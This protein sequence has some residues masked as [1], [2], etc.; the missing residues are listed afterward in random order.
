MK[1]LLFVL[2]FI[3]NICL[4]Q[5]CGGPFSKGCGGGVSTITVTSSGTNIA[6]NVGIGSSNPIA[7]LDVQGSLNL[8]GYIST[9][10]WV[11]CRVTPGSNGSICAGTNTLSSGSVIADT[12]GSINTASNSLVVA[13]ASGWSVGMGISVAQ[14]G[15]SGGTIELIT[16]IT[17]I[18]GTTFTLNNVSARSVNLSGVNVFHDDT[19]ALIA[20]VNGTKNV[21]VSLGNYNVTSEV[22]QVTTSNGLMIWGDGSVN[23]QT[24]SNPL[25]TVVGGTV[26]WN[27]GSTNN[28]INLTVSYDDVAYF[29]V[30][31]DASVTPSA[32]YAFKISDDSSG[33]HLRKPTI[34]DVSFFGVYN[35]ISLSGT[36][37]QPW[38]YNVFGNTINIA[39][40]INM[41]N[42]YG[43]NITNVN[44][45]PT[46][47]GN[48]IGLDIVSADESEYNNITY[49]G[50]DNDVLINDTG[51]AGGSI[52]SQRFLGGS[53]ENGNGVDP[54]VSISPSSTTTVS[55]IKFVGVEF[56][57]N[58]GAAGLL[59][60]T[61]STL[62]SILGCH[63][64]TM[65]TGIDDKSTIGFNTIND[66]TFKS[67]T[68]AVSFGTGTPSRVPG[69]QMTGNIG[70]SSVQFSNQLNLLSYSGNPNIFRV[71]TNTTDS[72]T[73]GSFIII[74]QDGNTIT[75]IGTRLGGI[76]W[77]G[78][79]GVGT[80]NVGSSI[81]SFTDAAW[82]A[83][84]APTNLRLTTA[85]TG[86][87]ARVERVRIDSSGNVGIGTTTPAQ[88]LEVN[89]TLN[90]FVVTSTGNVGINSLSP[91]AGLDV[92]GSIRSIAGAVV[93][94]NACWCTIPS[95]VLGNCTGVLG[96]C[97]ACNYNG[98]TC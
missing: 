35:G 81:E 91:G 22:K 70:D 96:T 49:T 37:V 68:T 20:A 32:G 40:L 66:N 60:D 54:L 98:A 7:A 80:F 28:I 62:V 26:I 25:P 63:F 15:N 92:Q 31:Q 6:P 65:S 34:H 38:V 95:K 4:A 85:P 39:T 12:T 48:G 42:G 78:T 44:L 23:N 90:A 73:S 2:L 14:A 79:I 16:Y 82:S 94:T 30:V 61:N 87:L 33:I 84:S 55:G 1:K 27:R 58:N 77:Q 29:T 64:Q 10:A 8:N 21:H 97:T 11:D 57:V 19:R 52:T 50:F 9:A 41:A 67:L 13:S 88:R 3:P 46:S 93:A 47:F 86:S 76:Q 18:S 83:S 71:K 75:P 36:V 69:L 24:L 5:F 56:G 43:V 17:A 74:S 72:S 51:G 59:L 45:N 89:G 53:F